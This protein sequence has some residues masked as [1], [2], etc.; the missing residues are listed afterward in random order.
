M[1]DEQTRHLLYDMERRIEETRCDNCGEILSISDWPFCPHD[2]AKGLKYFEDAV[3]GGF[4]AENGFDQPTRFDSHSEHRA[5]L[6]AR[7]MEI[8]AKWAG[9]NDKIMTRWDAPSAAT[10]E[11]AKVLLSR[12][13][14]E[15]FAPAEAY[16]PIPI[17]VTTVTY[18]K[19]P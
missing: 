2:H 15:P 10:L 4:W 3:P 12:K 18:A 11:S 17:T 14:S 1:I 8:G 7:G 9:P 6:A 16:E 19:E 13:K 5:A